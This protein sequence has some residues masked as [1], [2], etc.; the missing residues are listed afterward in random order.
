MGLIAFENKKWVDQSLKCHFILPTNTT[1]L[2][3]SASWSYQEG[4]QFQHSR[5]IAFEKLFTSK[6]CS[7]LKPPSLVVSAATQTQ[8][9]IVPPITSKQH[10]EFA[11][12]QQFSQ[13]CVCRHFRCPGKKSLWHSNRHFVAKRD[14]ARR[15]AS[16]RVSHFAL[17]KIRETTILEQDPPSH[18]IDGGLRLH[19]FL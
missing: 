17:W 13:A 7:S 10:V 2:L 19:P 14:R 4:P 3:S 1:A 6:D 11:Q 15:E 8:Y 5:S 18:K 9:C 16:A 12:S